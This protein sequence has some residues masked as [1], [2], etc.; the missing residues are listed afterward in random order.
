MSA[1]RH[2]DAL[3]ASWWTIARRLPRLSALAL[4]LAWAAAPP[5]SSRARSSSSP[6][7]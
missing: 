3:D 2:D 4:R 5:S 1:E 7:P 6:A